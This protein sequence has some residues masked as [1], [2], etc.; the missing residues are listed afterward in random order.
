MHLPETLRPAVGS[1]APARLYGG[2]H[3]TAPATL[4]QLS[5]AAD[6]VTRTFEARYVLEGDLARAPLGATVTIDIDAGDNA[7]AW[8]QVPIGA[9]FDPGQGPS[10]WVIATSGHIAR[11]AVQVHNLTD[12]AARVG[13]DLKAG[14]QVVALGAHL[15]QQGDKVRLIGPAEA[16]TPGERQ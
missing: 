4:R 8:L 14:E 9:I 12:D 16:G 13:G 3:T 5:D 6:R 15:L 11:R 10:V 2:G 1:R 7:M